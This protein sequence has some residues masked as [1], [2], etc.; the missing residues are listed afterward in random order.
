MTVRLQAMMRHASTLEKRARTQVDTRHQARFSTDARQS[1]PRLAN[2][3]VPLGI[4]EAIMA[5]QWWAL[6]PFGVCAWWWAPRDRG[7]EW[8]VA[9]GRGLITAEWGMVGAYALV[10]FPAKRAVVG[11]MWAGIPPMLAVFR[12]ARSVGPFPLG[13]RRDPTY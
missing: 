2:V 3:A 11:V 5:G 6:L 9:I 12:Q 4:A 1:R 13:M 10:A 8:V 7:W